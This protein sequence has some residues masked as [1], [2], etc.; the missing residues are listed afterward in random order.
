MS[1]HL[2][3]LYSNNELFFY[4]IF[5]FF[6]QAQEVRNLS[7][8]ITTFKVV[9]EKLQKLYLYCLD[10]FVLFFGV[11]FIWIDSHLELFSINICISLNYALIS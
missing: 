4:T 11:S 5:K 1:I 6:Q 3:F 2:M 10:Y 7:S 8:K 9:Y